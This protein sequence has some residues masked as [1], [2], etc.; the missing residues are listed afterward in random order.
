MALSWTP[1]RTDDGS[2]TFFSEEF[3]EAFHSSR[4]ARAEAFDK[5][6]EATKLVERAKGD[7]LQLLDVCYGLGYNTA[8]ALETV[9]AT[10]PQCCVTVYGLELDPTVP[11]AAT[12]PP[13]VDVWTPPL[14]SILQE[15]AHAQQSQRPEL[16][17]HLLIGD[18][19]QT[20]QP[21]AQ[22]GFQ[23]DAIFFDPFSPRRCPQLWTVEFFAQVAQCL[24]PG[25]IL[26]TYSRAASV[27]RAMQ[28]AGLHIGSMPLPVGD[29]LPHEWSQGTVASLDVVDLPP[30][31]P[32]EQEHLQT[33]AAIPYRD[34][35]LQE[36]PEAI[37]Q[38]HQQEQAAS[39]LESTSSWRRRW[40]I[41]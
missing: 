28:L 8:A 3:G 35:T 4:G 30:L 11:E 19:R 14:R 26:A 29:G 27:R 1:Q 12:Q 16:E 24:A 25:G 36:S 32:M 6:A 2:F 15:L 37:A 22:S 5:F 13:L 9:W 18:A 23:A 33:R 21:L 38:R 39:S 31:S 10:N 40:N 41:R 7:R 20:I 17:A 34:L